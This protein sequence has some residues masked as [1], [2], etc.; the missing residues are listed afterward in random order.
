MKTNA[1]MISTKLGKRDY[2]S[3]SRVDHKSTKTVTKDTD[4]ASLFSDAGACML[5]PA[6]DQG[7]LCR[8]SIRNVIS[9]DGN[10]EY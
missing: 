1:W 2:I 7:P 4:P 6:V 9:C 5:M 8:C 3:V 10:L